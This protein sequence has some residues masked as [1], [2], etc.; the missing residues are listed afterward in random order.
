MRRRTNP[1]AVLAMTGVAVGSIVLAFFIKGN[2]TRESREGQEPD[3][4]GHHCRRRWRRRIFVRKVFKSQMKEEFN[5]MNAMMKLKKA[6]PAVITAV[7]ML[8]VMAVPV[9][10]DGDGAAVIQTGF[11]TLLDIVKALVSAIGTIVLLWGLFEWGTSLQ[12]PNGAE[13]SSAFKRI[14]GGLVM[15]LAPQL[16]T[17]FIS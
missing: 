15:I 12:S 4:L 17:L 8:A 1:K 9:F 13:Q 14:G 16:I 7:I 2:L 5:K 3:L 10:A 11:A 6:V